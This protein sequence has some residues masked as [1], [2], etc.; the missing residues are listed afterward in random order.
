MSAGGTG[1]GAMPGAHRQ[2]PELPA[3][4]IHATRESLHAYARVLGAWLSHC[5]PRRKHWWH[6]SLRPTLNGLGTGVVH[7]PLD[8]ELELDL[9]ASVLHVRTSPADGTGGLFAIALHGQSAAEL[10]ADIA[11]FLRARG[12]PGAL[13]PEPGGDAASGAPHPDYSRERAGAMASA[14]GTVSA[15]M[16]VLRAG[17]PE[18]TSPI[19][20]WPHHFDLSMLWL[21]GA[22][23]PGE[24]P[25]DEERSDTQMN[26]GFAFG[27]ATVPEPYVYVTAYP[28]PDA[29]AETPLPPGAAWLS[30]G[31][32]GAVLPW[33]RLRRERDPQAHLLALW[34]GLLEAGRKHML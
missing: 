7:G 12:L 11:T 27:D 33:A 13:V 18:E 20:L 24:D 9:A 2:L 26:F 17:I 32:T 22:K 25:A 10:A 3:E 8:F 34:R 31:F 1:A 15:A 5:R 16:S 19:Q 14:L 29:L 4:A 30:E 23:I 21:P 28:S 6:A